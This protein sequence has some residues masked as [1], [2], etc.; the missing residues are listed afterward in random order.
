MLVSAL[1]GDA[2]KL[3]GG[4]NLSKYTVSPKEESAELSNKMGLWVGGGF[5]L[6]LSEKIFL[7]FDLLLLQKGSKVKFPALPDLKSNY[8]L[9]TFSIPALAGIK[10]RRNLPVY[11]FGGAEFSLILSHALVKKSG[12]AAD[13]QDLKE[14]TKSFDFGLVFGCG[15]EVKVSKFQS[16][17]IEGRYHHGFMNI[18]KYSD[19]Y[20]SM[21]TSVILF[22]LGIKSY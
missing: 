21:K 14:N 17:F 19:Q 20:E 13:E 10:F 16:I 2:F 6:D 5:E 1:Y 8:N 7:E 11:I 15:F 4:L 18:I 22:V 3:M 9:S 12:E